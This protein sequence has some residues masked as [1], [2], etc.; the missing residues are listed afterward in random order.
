MEREAKLTSHGEDG[1]LVAMSLK[2]GLEGGLC[3]AS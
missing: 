2:E 1:V 3:R